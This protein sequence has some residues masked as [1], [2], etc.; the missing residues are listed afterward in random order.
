VLGAAQIRIEAEEAVW[1]VSGDYKRA[2]DPTCKPFEIVPCDTFVTEATFALPLFRWPDPES[3]IAEIASWWRENRA[4]GRASVLF[5]YALGKAPRL[6]AGLAAHLEEP[7]WTHG[8]IESV[9]ALYREAGISLPETRPVAETKKKDLPPG[10]L[11]LA[12]LSASGTPWMR[13]FPGAQT[14]FASGLMRI[15]GTRRRKGFDR[16][17]VLSDHADWPALLRT[18]AETGAT[19]VRT[20]H[21]HAHVLARYL[22]EQGQDAE[23]LP[24]PHSGEADIA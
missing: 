9:V 14:G 13:R 24:S 23:V 2:P 5:A 3:V 20:T 19:R 17:F 7:I 4:A 10:P 1:V 16:G 11:V 15:R 8:A 22:E 21:G 18:I 12:P 6:M